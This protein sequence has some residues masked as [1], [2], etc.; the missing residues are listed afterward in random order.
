MI[1]LEMDWIERF[2]TSFELSCAFPRH[3]HRLG[4]WEYPPVGK[5]NPISSY[6]FSQGFWAHHV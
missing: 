3:F 5:V 4:L 6:I 1:R 2:F